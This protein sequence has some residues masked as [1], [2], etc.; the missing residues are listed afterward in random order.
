[1]YRRRCGNPSYAVVV[2][3]FG[4]DSKT[5]Y[6]F[7]FMTVSFSAIYHRLP[8]KP[9]YNLSN[10]FF[11]YFCVWQT[12]KTF[13]RVQLKIMFT[14]THTTEIFCQTLHMVVEHFYGVPP[15]KIIQNRI[16]ALCSQT[17]RTHACFV[18]VL[19]R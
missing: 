10:C 12:N 6:P 7:N 14:K 3:S 13:I 1:M 5:L 19:G 2:V 8:R 15:Y 17:T 9:F 11:T 16:C 18:S 4:I